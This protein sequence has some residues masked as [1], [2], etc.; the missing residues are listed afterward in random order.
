MG[1]NAQRWHAVKRNLTQDDADK[2]RGYVSNIPDNLKDATLLLV[3]QGGNITEYL[4]GDTE[5]LKTAGRIDGFTPTPLP[6]DGEPELPEG[7]DACAHP[8]VPLSVTLADKS[9]IDKSKTDW[10]AIRSAVEATL[11]DDKDCYVS[12]TF[13]RQGNVESKRI[14]NWVTDEYGH[15][16]DDTQMGAKMLCS[17]LSIGIAGSSNTEAKSVAQRIGATVCPTYTA[18]GAHASRPKFALFATLCTL[19]VLT[20]LI[21]FLHP[22]MTWKAV[23]FTEAGLLL[24]YLLA[25]A[26]S[27]ISIVYLNRVYITCGWLAMAAYVPLLMLNVPWWAFL[28]PLALAVPAFL[29]WQSWTA[30]DDIW[31]KPRRYYAFRNG[32][33][34]ANQSDMVNQYGKE[35]DRKTL[36]TYGTHHSTLL[37]IPDVLAAMLIPD[38]A[39]Q[40]AAQN[41][42]PASAALTKGG[43]LLGKDQTGRDTYLTVPELYGG[44]AVFGSAGSGKSVLTHGIMQ[45]A[46]SNRTTTDPKDWGS[47]SRVI[48]FQMKD[49][50]GV[51]VMQAYR[52]AN[53]LP[54]AK[55]FRIL[56]SDDAHNIDILGMKAGLDASATAK[57]A[58]AAMQFAF[59]DGDIRGSSLD[60]LR[61]ALTIGIAVQRHLD[62]G[63]MQERDMFS[64]RITELEPRYHGAANMRMQ[65][66]PMGWALV[67]LCGAEGGVGAAR[68]LGAVCRALALEH[69]EEKDM[70]HAATAAEQLYG[71]AD[72]KATRA[73]DDR[74][75]NRT[76]AP[77]NK[78]SRFTSVEHLFTTH[79]GTVT[80][81]QILAH[82][83]DYHVAFCDVNEPG[84]V[85]VEQS[86]RAIIAKWVM[87]TMWQTV[88]SY[89]QSWQLQGKHTMFVCDEV[90]LLA[91]AE[92]TVLCQMKD[93]GRSFGWIPVLATQFPEKLPP[94][95]MHSVFNYGTLVSFY[96]SDKEMASMI[97]MQ[98]HDEWTPE[99]VRGLSR[100]RHALALRTYAPDM[101]PPCIVFAKDF[102]AGYRAR[103]TNAG[104]PLES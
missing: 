62:M 25:Y 7:I 16:E 101:Q 84:G 77:R 23:A 21:P 52:K 99:T 28:I 11:P 60:V 38:S 56:K 24:A 8:V 51:E 87:Y 26:V 66:T 20:A 75:L 44:I 86:L 22:L 27:T 78:V 18:M 3:K 30:W 42:Y 1:T 73:S 100:E 49:M 10:T 93:Q 37:I 48:D 47:D 19:T 67:A 40:E 83:E 35:S 79:R 50:E 32:T 90:S 64:K 57:Q 71:H 61:C 91:D 82:A 80:W 72:E 68:A 36:A 103:A 63:G 74:I 97:A 33:R 53:G 54:T 31:Q 85:Q 65:S 102:D 41:L 5:L 76:D 70:E 17:R 29:R 2:R 34:T 89:C 69:P 14:R 95:L 45:W 43:I 4:Y 39:G 81:R 98:M 15:A 12:F 55:T 46:S 88:Q 6:D 94:L 59:D 9:A 92:S 58:A 104:I 13:R 96:L